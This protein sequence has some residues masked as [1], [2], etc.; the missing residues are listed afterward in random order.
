MAA[1]LQEIAQLG[2]VDAP[3]LSWKKVGEIERKVQD[4][5]QM[6]ISASMAAIDNSLF[7][8]GDKDKPLLRIRP[9]DPDEKKRVVALDKLARLHSRWNCSSVVYKVVNQVGELTNAW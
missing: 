8:L 1:A 5:H 3:G 2:S 7:L 9:E 4:A 6:L